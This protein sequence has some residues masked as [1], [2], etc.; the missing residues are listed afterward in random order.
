MNAPRT[1]LF[2]LCCVLILVRAEA[3]GKPPPVAKP[4]PVPPVRDDRGTPHHVTPTVTTD[5][6]RYK[7]EVT[8][9][10]TQLALTYAGRQVGIWDGSSYYRIL[11][12]DRAGNVREW[13]GPEAVPFPLPQGA[14][15]DRGGYIRFRNQP[16]QVVNA[17]PAFSP[18]NGF[19]GF[20][21]FQGD[22]FSSEN[23][24]GGNCGTGPI[25]RGLGSRGGLFGRRR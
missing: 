23:C 9:S 4:L 25:Q 20:N 6:N 21:G 24:V 18:V 10:G 13:S 1:L 17:T 16:A 19:Q 8:D 22:G 7:W 12:T 3:Q 5:D 14:F 15:L 2:A 11:L